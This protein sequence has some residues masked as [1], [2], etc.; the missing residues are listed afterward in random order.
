MVFSDCSA[1]HTKAFGSRAFAS[2]VNWSG[3]PGSAAPGS[4]AQASV[5]DLERKLAANIAH[6]AAREFMRTVRERCFRPATY[7]DEHFMKNSPLRQRGTSDCDNSS[8][9]S[10]CQQLLSKCFHL[11]RSP[12]GKLSSAKRR[13]TQLRLSVLVLFVRHRA[14]RSRLIAYRH[15]SI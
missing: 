2:Q 6:I 12:V 4:N 1:A 8:K 7:F 9:Q 14:Y 11:R 5:C 3:A 15:A 10:L 13:P